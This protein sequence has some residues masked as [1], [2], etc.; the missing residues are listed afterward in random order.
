MKKVNIMMLG[1]FIAT[2]SAVAG[3]QVD[4]LKDR[5]TA[6]EN[7]KSKIE[8]SGLIEVGF[9]ENRAQ[10]EALVETVELGITANLTQDLSANLVLLSEADENGD[11]T[12]VSID[13]A[14]L[15]GNINGVDFTVGKLTAPF[16]AYETAMISDPAGLDIGETGVRAL[17]FSTE[18]NGLT[19]SAWAG[20]SKIGG[21]KSKDNNG[22]S[23]GYEGDFLVVGVDTIRDAVPDEDTLDD[24]NNKGVA[25][26][27]Q[28]S[29][30]NITVIA[31]QV[32][33]KHNDDAV[34]DFKEQQL[35]LQYA[36]DSWTLA[37]RM[38]RGDT[39]SSAYGMSYAIA[40]GASVTVENHKPDGEKA[41][42]SVKLA[43]EF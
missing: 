23:I 3:T 39:K 35:E 29:F 21:G 41:T 25:I 10:G 18:I 31:E 7:V 16:G 1:A 20:N 42:F 34:A 5:I 33:V 28:V 19:L 2:T 36:T 13:E 6:L 14:T 43:Y 17:V 4:A 22:L 32:T 9:E 30:N 8:F 24:I 12:D 26:H 37:T 38:D 27:G 11:L 15:N 40:E